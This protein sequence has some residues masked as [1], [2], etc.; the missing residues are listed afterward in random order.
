MTL[1]EHLAQP[2]VSIETHIAA[3][4]AALATSLAGKLPIYL[5]TR[6]WIVVR[7]VGDGTSTRPDEREIVSLLERLVERGVAFCP[8]SEATFSELMRQ[9]RE[10]QRAATASA[11][12]KLSCGVT[13]HPDPDRMVEEADRVVLGRLTTG[14]I[15]PLA[16]AWTSL[17]YV[18]GDMYPT[19]TPLPAEQELA[20]QKAFYDRMWEEPLSS[21]ALSMDSESYTRDTELQEQAR[22][23]TQ[24][25]AEHRGS[26]T[27]FESV[28]EQEFHGV[29]LTIAEASPSL[30]SALGPLGAR[31]KIDP[32]LL[33]T[34]AIREMLKDLDSARAMPTAHVHAVVHALF[35]WEYRDK[36]IT[37]N[38]L[39]D[40]RHAAAAL[41]HCDL[42][43]TE[44]GLRRTLCHRRMPLA[45][46]HRTTVL[47]DRA[48]IVR[49]LRKLIA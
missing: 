40:F 42:L 8:I 38:D 2:D 18:L 34:N 41:S 3:R 28:L 6:F 37:A 44:G 24:L 21:I 9:G 39:V 29:A 23:L 14:K 17:A 48:G 35:R 4:A 16:P 45:E 12:E 49:H 31:L 19:A 36:P 25:N 20:I 10:A 43:L 46:I 15:P 47:S 22:R 26:M 32:L 30:R 1:V 27:S 7:E 11:I 5:D 13:I 33:F